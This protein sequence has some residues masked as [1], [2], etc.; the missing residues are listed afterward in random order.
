MESRETLA[1]PCGKSLARLRRFQKRHQTLRS[2]PCGRRAL[3]TTHSAPH[4]SAQAL[5]RGEAEA[6]PS[7]WHG[8][9]T[10]SHP[11]PVTGSVWSHNVAVQV[12]HRWARGVA[13]LAVRDR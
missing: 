5:L 12:R 11:P 13:Q 6:W 4:T 10:S 3:P 2:S 9:Q 7:G 8:T 1:A